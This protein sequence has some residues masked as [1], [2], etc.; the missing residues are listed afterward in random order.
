M[1]LP[2][3]PSHTAPSEFGCGAKLVMTA[4]LGFSYQENT[5]TLLRLFFSNINLRECFVNGIIVILSYA[6]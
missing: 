3:I 4:P 5:I 1:S 2:F 6:A